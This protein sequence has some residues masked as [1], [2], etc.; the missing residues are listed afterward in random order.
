MYIIYVYVYCTYIYVYIHFINHSYC[1]YKST[2]LRDNVA[3]T[4]CGDFPLA[5]CFT[6]V[7]SVTLNEGFVA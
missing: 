3:A 6:G 1:S 5:V 2:C 7:E 4:E